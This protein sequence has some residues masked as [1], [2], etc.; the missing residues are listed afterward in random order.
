VKTFFIYGTA[1]VA[2]LG[3]GV[4]MAVSL[5]GPIAYISSF[6]GGLVIGAAAAFIDAAA[7]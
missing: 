5:D 1:V 2:A 3:W 4:L 7:D 6:V